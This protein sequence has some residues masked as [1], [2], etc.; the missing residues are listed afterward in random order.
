MALLK[1]NFLSLF[2]NKALLF[3]TLV[4][5]MVLGIFFKFA[6]SNLEKGDFFT[7]INIAIIDSEDIPTGFLDSIG[8]AKYNNEIPLFNYELKNKDEAFELLE[9]G[10]ISGVIEIHSNED[11]TLSVV[12]GGFKQTIIKSFLDQYMQINASIKSLVV[13]SHGEA[14]IEDIIRDLTDQTEYLKDMESKTKRTSFISHFFF[15]LVGMAVLYGSFWGTMVVERI[16]P[17]N[18]NQGIRL[19]ISPVKRKNLLFIGMFSSFVIHFL[20]MIV[21]ILFLKYVLTVDFNTNFIFLVITT[22]L[23]AM[24]AISFGALIAML[25]RRKS[26]GTKIAVTIITSMAGSFL[27]GMM[28]MDVKYY[29]QTNVP[30]LQYINP[31]SIITDALFS[32]SYYTDYSRF[33]TNIVILG[34]MT[35]VFLTVTAILFRRD[36][37]E[38]I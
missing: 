19:S 5:P 15:T 4:F 16:I 33:I 21:I 24:L 18:E 30:F 37:Y 8:G 14:N 36:S 9:N 22:G 2:K 10:K 11:I 32:L 20:E 28:N 25:L 35:V 12:S 7:T 1:Y 31:V 3:W 23:G 27:A 13:L 6:F 38:S 34:V 17:T 29:V 26:E